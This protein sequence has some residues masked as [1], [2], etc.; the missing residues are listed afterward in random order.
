MKYAINLA[1]H[2]RILS[3]TYAKY[4][5]ADAVLVDEL[6]DGN[7]ADYR[8]ADGEFIHDPIP[9]EEPA[10]PKASNEERITELE[11]A[12]EMLLNGVTE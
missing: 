7:V 9:E 10:E 6:P 8:Y 12:L 3:V 1:E 5:A 4:A 11:E 2:G